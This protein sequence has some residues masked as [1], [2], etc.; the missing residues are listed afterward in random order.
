VKVAGRQRYVYRAIDRFGQVIGVVVSPRRDAVAAR[1][2][3]QQAIS[4][5]KVTPVEV[6]TDHASVSAT[7]SSEPPARPLRAGG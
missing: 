4:A 6:V 3:F 2:C 1:R 7:P 5:T